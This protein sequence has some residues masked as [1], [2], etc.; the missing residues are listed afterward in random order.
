MCPGITNQID[1]E[2]LGTVAVIDGP[3]DGGEIGCVDR[4]RLVRVEVVEPTLDVVGVQWSL[5][6][7]FPSAEI[8]VETT[9]QPHCVHDSWLVAVHHSDFQQVTVPRGTDVE[10]HL[11]CSWN[12]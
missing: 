3:S 1:Q 7:L 12:Y 8:S 11:V 2:R 9:A 10:D 4:W 5:A 6:H